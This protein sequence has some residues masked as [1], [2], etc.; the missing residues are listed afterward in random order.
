M[1]FHNMTACAFFVASFAFFAEANVVLAA[2]ESAA[3]LGDGG[4]PTKVLID[5]DKVRVNLITFPTNHVRDG[6][7]VRRTDQVLIYL[8]EGD[9]VTLNEAGQVQ[10]PTGP[11]KA[12][13]PAECTEIKI[14]L[15]CGPIGPDGKHTD[16]HPSG[17]I[18]WRPKGNP[19]GKL[20][21]TKGYRAL[22]VELKHGTATAADPAAAKLPVEDK[23][24]GGAPA[25]VIIDNEVIRAT[26]VSYPKDFKR[27]GGRRRALDQL[28]VYLDDGEFQF[29]QSSS[30]A[31]PT[32]AFGAAS[33]D[34]IKDCGPVGP[35]GQFKSGNLHPSGTVAWHP[36]DTRTETIRTGKAYRAVYL[37]LKK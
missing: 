9:F 12:G 7:F 14:G 20:K 27:E 3:P 22:Y 31:Q 32:M 19:G 34:K 13:R 33:C 1:N 6:N 36:K 15:D 35:D 4:A 28:V 16:L 21:I 25:R 37:E 24:G 18:S 30:G 5:N 2:G 23:I 26:I 8:D 29:A 11:S 10:P 17:A